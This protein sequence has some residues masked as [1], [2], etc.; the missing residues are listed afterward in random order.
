MEVNTMNGTLTKSEWAVM[1]ALWVKSP[2]PL[3]HVIKMMGDAVTWGYRTYATHLNKLC[4]KG[5]VGFEIDRGDKMYYPLVSR[6]DCIKQESQA[7]FDKVTAQTAKDLLLCM[8]RE[9]GLSGR[10]H[11]ELRD[12]LE[13]LAKEGENK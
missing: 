10:D 12:L 8:I 1:E 9:G 3:S 7:V 4:E 5:A 2:A 6:E 11:Q 13:E